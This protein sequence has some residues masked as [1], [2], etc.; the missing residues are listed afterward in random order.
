M[1]PGELQRRVQDTIDERIDSGTE[2]GVQVVVI[3]GGRLVV[4]V[5]S[6]LA[7][8]SGRIVQPDTLFW[9]ASTAKGVASTVAHVLAERGVLDYDLPPAVWP[10]FA[11]HGK[12]KVTI[13]HVLCHIAGVPGLT[14][15]FDPGRTVRLGAHVHPSRRRGA[16]VG[17]RHSLRIPRSHLWLSSG[18]STP[19]ADRPHDLGPAT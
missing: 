9:A 4:N 3:H 7:D 10:E 13:R 8:A 19:P 5:A 18:R 12:H 1:T 14:G 6:G 16:V 2:L 15:Q 17:T 11:A